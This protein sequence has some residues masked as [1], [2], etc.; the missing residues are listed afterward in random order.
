MCVCAGSDVTTQPAVFRR[1]VSKY[2]RVEPY[3]LQHAIRLQD[4]DDDLSRY[5]PRRRYAVALGHLQ[6]DSSSLRRVSFF[7]QPPSYSYMLVKYVCVCV[8]MLTRVTEI[9]TAAHRDLL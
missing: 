9:A 1:V 2:R 3:Q 6:L 4:A 7:A 8:W 5:R